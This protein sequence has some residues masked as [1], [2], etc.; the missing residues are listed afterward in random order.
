MKH[1]FDDLFDPD[2]LSAAES[3]LLKRVHELI[4]EAGPPAGHV[5]VAAP[6]AA[7]SDGGFWSVPSRLAGG[8]AL[9]LAAVALIAG[10][11]YFVLAG[12]RPG[13]RVDAAQAAAAAL[14]RQGV[15]V[16]GESLAGVQLGDT[17]DDVRALWGHN[18][19]VCANCSV[20]TWF[21]IYPTGDP[22]GA[23]VKFRDGRVTAV[24]T[25]GAPTGWRD[26]EGVRVGQL[27]EPQ[28]PGEGDET[29]RG[30]LG[31]GAKSTREGEAVSSVL[32]QG[33]AVYGFALT[34]PS[35]PVCQ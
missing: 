29:W 4:V 19:T 3:A 34:L 15:L 35:E 1:E 17:E 20:T 32:T 21:Y 24:F 2:G 16:H 9:G 33:L 14:P 28:E 11:V 26:D 6:V 22:F 10:G 23:A 25:L 13:P 12:S 8:F 7:P 31:Y 5:P 18:F 30:C 27:L